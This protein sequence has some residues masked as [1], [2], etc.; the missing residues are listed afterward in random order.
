MGFSEKE[1]TMARKGRVDSI[2]TSNKDFAAPGVEGQKAAETGKEEQQ[3]PAEPPAVEE[4]AAEEPVSQIVTI[5]D[6]LKIQ[7]AKGAKI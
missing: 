4:P 7:R 3:P 5:E 1:S 6:V 2:T